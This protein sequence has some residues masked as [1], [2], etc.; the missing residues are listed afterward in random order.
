MAAEPEAA[1]L[2]PGLPA[3]SGTDGGRIIEEAVFFFLP[4]QGGEAGMERMLRVEEGLLA[5]RHRRVA[6]L[7]VVV[8]IEL[9]RAQ[10]Q[11]DAA[12][13]GGMRVGVEGGVDEVGELAGEAV[14]LDDVGPFD[15]AEVGAAAALVDAQQRV[16]AVEGGAVDVEVVGQELADGG[17]AAGVVGPEARK[18]GP[19]RCCVPAAPRL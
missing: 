15:L 5:V 12:E 16:E 8:A 2:E 18:K 14:Q 10:R 4:G 9:P 1:L 19:C 7:G 6:G 17:A 11:A 3:G 13:Q